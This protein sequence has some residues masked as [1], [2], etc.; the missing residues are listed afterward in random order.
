MAVVSIQRFGLS[1]MK[2][3]SKPLHAGSGSGTDPGAEGL[4]VRWR[5]H[6][7]R[8]WISTDGVHYSPFLSRL[9]LEDLHLLDDK[10]PDWYEKYLRRF[11]ESKNQ[12]YE[13]SSWPM[14][15]INEVVEEIY[16][17]ERFGMNGKGVKDFDVHAKVGTELAFQDML[18]TGETT[19]RL[20][21]NF[22]GKFHVWGLSAQFPDRTENSIAYRWKVT[23]SKIPIAEFDAGFCEPFMTYQAGKSYYFLTRSGRLFKTTA[24]EGGKVVVAA[25]WDD[26]RRP[27]QAIISDSD[28]NRSFAFAGTKEGW[29]TKGVYFELGPKADPAEYDVSKIESAKAEAPLPLLRQL[30]QV[31]I[32]EGK[33]KLPKPAKD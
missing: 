13:Y 9:G 16:K 31:L 15:K 18:P 3:I 17:E 4:P 2:P 25:Y 12:S 29:Q 24:S 20:F 5:I 27:I 10:A 11:P 33:I 23:F 21:I 1:G 22:E 7:K 26:K 30:T 28:N 8:L 19:G 6:E 32:D 14:R